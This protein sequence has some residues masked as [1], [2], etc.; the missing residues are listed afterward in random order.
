MSDQLSASAQLLMILANQA[1]RRLNHRQADSR[2]LVIGITKLNES[3]P[4]RSIL[5]NYEITY[6]SVIV[7]V[8][9]GDEPPGKHM[10]FSEDVWE[11]RQRAQLMSSKMG[12]D[13][14]EPVHLLIATVQLRDNPGSML[15]LSQFGSTD[16]VRTSFDIFIHAYSCLAD[17]LVAHGTQAG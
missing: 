7:V 1:A 15:L 14:I 17:G 8:P 13:A 6:G 2:H 5:A 3:D 12:C 9:E 4:A 11:A 16:P 10:P